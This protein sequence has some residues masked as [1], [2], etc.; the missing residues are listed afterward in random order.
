[1]PH[2]LL[3]DHLS[4]PTRE[5]SIPR[6]LSPRQVG[7][8]TWSNVLEGHVDAITSVV[9][10]ESQNGTRIVSG[11]DDGA[12]RIWDWRHVKKFAPSMATSALLARSRAP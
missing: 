5:L 12:V 7:W 6:L 11:S 2:C 8:G 4:V 9:F 10:F 1:M 3:L